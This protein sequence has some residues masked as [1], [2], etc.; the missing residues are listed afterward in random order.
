MYFK[1]RGALILS[2]E[3][4][5]SAISYPYS[6]SQ[7]NTIT[8]N[9]FG[10]VEVYPWPVYLNSTQNNLMLSFSSIQF[11]VKNQPP[12]SYNCT[13][14]LVPDDSATRVSFLSKYTYRLYMYFG[15]TF[16][17]SSR[18]VCPYVFKNAQLPL[19]ITLFD[20]VDSFLFV[21]LFRFQTDDWLLNETQIIS[22]NSNVAMLHIFH[23]FNLKLDT[24]LFHP[25][26]FEKLTYLQCQGTIKS[27]Q[28]GLFKHLQQPL[29]I[30]FFLTSLGNFYHQIGIEWMMSLSNNSTLVLRSVL[31]YDYPDRDFC[32]FSHI[33]QNKDL[34]ITF[35]PVN[36]NTSLTYSWLTQNWGG[37]TSNVSIDTNKIKEMLKICDEKRNDTDNK[38]DQ[39]L[40]SYPSY[41]DFYQAR[42]AGMLFF[43]LVPF[44]L[45]PCACFIGFF[46][47]WKII[48]TLA[49]NKKK[50]LKEDF[51]K[52]MSVNAKLNCIFCLIFVFYPMTS[53]NWRLSTT[54][55]ST[56][57]TSQFV[58]YFKIVIM[59]YFGEVVKMCAN[60]TYIMMTLNRYLLVGQ[61]HPPWLLTIAKFEFKWVIRGS[62]L[63][64]AII[65][66]GH[67]W[68]YQAEKIKF[69]SVPI[70]NSI[71]DAAN[72]YS[73]SDYP[74]ANQSTGYFILTVVYFVIDFALFFTLNTGIEVKLV[75]RMHK[76]LIDKKE[77]LA[78]MN[79]SST[80]V[81]TTFAA[82]ASTIQ[83]DKDKKLKED[84][85]SK[86][87][88]KVI[89]MVI[90]NGILNFV[91]RAPELLFW[92]EN[93]SIFTAA[94]PQQKVIPLCYYIPGILIFI[95]DISYFS[96]I[97][98]F[99]TNF[100]I[101]YKFNSNFKEAVMFF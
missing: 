26:V 32:I 92:L 14:D 83:A 87:E 12:G 44:V 68:Q 63:L 6:D 96:Y 16:G 38:N 64:S 3:L 10:G 17:S 22:I 86:K 37:V 31:K 53:C 99:T 1:P 20:Q 52:Y 100:I 98:T 56:I 40:N 82:T 50:K 8:L 5:I 73:Y 72:G 97:L 36:G 85:D 80:T 33:P 76:E 84:E 43:E 90:F 69:V 89:K 74:Q 39:K 49:T 93:A 25:I 29:G 75:R 28:T 18:V 23:V 2:E 57:F 71:Y 79:A 88:K 54:F 41:Y 51:Y 30:D 42:L 24:G 58:Q 46:L 62:F 65:N 47:N 78:K 66:I 101:F 21:S 67:G 7:Y 34:S 45:I 19:G 27:I 70:Y 94:F 11:Y 77:R 91:L 9:D 4:N 35:D 59:A 95:A 13:P 55:C 60:I 48:Q 81:E 61:D 15:N